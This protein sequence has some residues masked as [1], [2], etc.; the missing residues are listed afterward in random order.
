MNSILKKILSL[1]VFSLLLFPF[2]AFAQEKLS[3]P[4]LVEVKI[5]GKFMDKNEVSISQDQA[6][7]LSGSAAVGSQAFLYF[8]TSAEPLVVTA[9]VDQNGYWFYRLSQALSVGEHKLEAETHKGEEISAKV[10]LMQFQVTPS[11]EAAV[12]SKLPISTII[13]ISALG[14]LV[15]IGLGW[16]LLRRVK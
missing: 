10:E 3:P 14:L 12:T 6:M 5:D 8:S 9:D 1:A 2:A 7:E 4:N 13:L 11:T 15:L 16:L